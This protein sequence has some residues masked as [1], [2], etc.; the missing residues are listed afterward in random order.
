MSVKISLIHS[1]PLFKHLSE[2]EAT[3]IAQ[4]ANVRAI[5]QNK[6]I[7]TSSREQSQIYLVLEGEMHNVLLNLEGK[8]VNIEIIK[9]GQFTGWIES[10]YPKPL[11]KNLMSIKNSKILFFP[12]TLGKRLIMSNPMINSYVLETAGKTIFNMLQERLILNL[13]STYQRIYAFLIH[14]LEN[15]N[16]NDPKTLIFPKQHDIASMLNTSRET[17]SRALQ[18]LVKQGILIKEGHRIR[19]QQPQK[20]R[21]LAGMN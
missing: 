1:I 6:L 4:D 5:D 13:P 12:A 17:V 19:I 3:L 21:D 10:I 15:L 20:L 18:L 16:P 14:S 2:D 8:P 9:S 11:S 7:T